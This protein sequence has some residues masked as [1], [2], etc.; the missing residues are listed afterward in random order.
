MYAVKHGHVEVVKRLVECEYLD[1][2][3]KNRVSP[4][5]SR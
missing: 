3:V 1:C 5:L 4:E 2:N